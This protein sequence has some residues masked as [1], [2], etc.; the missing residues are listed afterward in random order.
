M[1][2]SNLTIGASQNAWHELLGIVN[3]A[4]A[5]KKLASGNQC[6]LRSLRFFQSQHHLL[7]LKAKKIGED[8]RTLINVPYVGKRSEFEKWLYTFANPSETILMKV[9]DDIFSA[10]SNNIFSHHS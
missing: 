4:V 2:L 10:F 9:I 5:K 3:A 8:S 1:C 7:A 6:T